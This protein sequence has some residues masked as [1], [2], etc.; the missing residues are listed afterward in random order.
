M[1]VV[2]GTHNTL[3]KSKVVVIDHTLIA[4]AHHRHCYTCDRIWPL[5][6]IYLQ[7]KGLV[8]SV[9]SLLSSKYQGGTHWIHF[10]LKQSGKVSRNCI[11]GR[12]C[13][14]KHEIKK[15]LNLVEKNHTEN[16]GC[17]GYYE[18]NKERRRFELRRLALVRYQNITTGSEQKN[19]RGAKTKDWIA[20][21]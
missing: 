12:T 13:T 20:N 3:S 16:W 7:H 1:V 4:E 18:D 11:S 21:E 19:I 6:C 8:L 17:S 14:K 2:C 9:Y 10:Q 15:T 5:T